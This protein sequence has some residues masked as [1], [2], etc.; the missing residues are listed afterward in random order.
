MVRALVLRPLCHA[1]RMTTRCSAEPQRVVVWLRNDLRTHDNAALELARSLPHACVLP[2]YVSQQA[3]CRLLE[4]TPRVGPHRARAL[5][6]ALSDL[7]ARLRRAGSGLAVLHGAPEDAIA[8][9][10]PDLVLAQAEPCVEERGAESRLAAALRSAGAS[11]RL[12]PLDT[13]FAAECLPFAADLS[14]VPTSGVTFLKRVLAGGQAPVPPR[15]VDAAAP[16]LQLGPAW[17]VL[18]ELDAPLGA[19]D[20][21][22]GETAA[23]E[24]LDELL[25]RSDA[26]RG[27]AATRNELR[28]GTGLSAHLALGCLSVR[29]VAAELARYDA[30]RPGAEDATGWAPGG[31]RFELGVR[32][33]FRYAAQR[34]GAALFA[35][36]GPVPRSPPQHWSGDAAALTAWRAGQTGVPLI[37]A[38]QRQLRSEGHISN[39]SRQITASWAVLA[40]GLDWRACA[41]HFE[42]TLCD[43]DPSANAGNW[44]AVAGMSGGR[45]NWFNVALQAA[46]YDA[47]GDFVRHFVPELAR[48]P[49][50][51]IH[52]PWTLDDAA[53][54][55]AGVVLGPGGTYP[56]AELH[57]L[58]SPPP[59]KS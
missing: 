16:S 36:Q 37:D 12:L 47:G 1:R 38:I 11:L 33:F 48:L 7:R 10:R 44:L 9:L 17:E 29:T 18:P 5:A 23:L 45:E 42:S 34:W 50:E 19:P 59:R 49:A 26:V 21:P 55:Q 31:L 24:A 46:K 56:R 22:G 25:W 32:D 20:A 54:A 13:L 30:A 2:V 43:Y 14:D 53:C 39:R 8:A 28:G 15:A 27:Y 58:R 52:A 4:H 51:V 57:L 41:E 40:R 35:E 3:P 6:A